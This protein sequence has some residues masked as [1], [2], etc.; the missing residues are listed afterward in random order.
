MLALQSIP[1]PTGELPPPKPAGPRLRRGPLESRDEFLLAQPEL[2]LPAVTPD[3]LARG[4]TRVR[5]AADWGNDFGYEKRRI[6]NSNRT[7]YL[8]DGEHRSAAL[9]VDHGLTGAWSVHARLPVLWR[10]GGVLD[11]LIDA[12]HRLTGLPD[13][14]RPL[15]PRNE[16]SVIALDHT[17]QPLHWTAPAG[18]GLGGLELG[19]RFSSPSRTAGWTTA[20]EARIQLPTGTAGYERRGV[21]VGVQ[22]LAAATLG[23]CGDV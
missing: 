16:L 19:T 3:A 2:T 4:R 20:M 12:W 18:S 13:S 14:N 11:G 9:Q 23:G 8:V 6:T 5:M 10:G 15:Y 17:L 22:G 7:L 1:R 21:Q